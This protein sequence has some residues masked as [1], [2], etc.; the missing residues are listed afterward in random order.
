MK[1]SLCF[2][3]KLRR[4]SAREFSSKNPVEKSK[5][6]SEPVRSSRGSFLSL[7]YFFQLREIEIGFVRG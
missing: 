2:I 4:S 7:D 3:A 5:A 6:F 1:S